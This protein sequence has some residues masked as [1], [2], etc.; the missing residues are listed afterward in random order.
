M[1][2]DKKI[3]VR[4]SKELHR[5]VKMRSAQTGQT[6]SDKVRQCLQEWVEEDEQA[7]YSKRQ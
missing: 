6:I 4:L 7:N 2:N 1:A 3:V 5:K